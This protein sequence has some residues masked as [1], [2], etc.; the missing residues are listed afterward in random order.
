MISPL[1]A[2][3]A[4]RTGTAISSNTTYASGNLTNVLGTNYSG[5]QTGGTGENV[6][7]LADLSVTKS[8]P[9]TGFAG[10]T[11]T[12]SLVGRNLGRAIG[13]QTFS[14]S[15]ATDVIAANVS[16]VLSA[17]PIRITD[18]L[19][20]GVSLDASPTGTNW[21]CT[22]VAGNTS[23]S[24]GYFQPNPELAYPLAS[25]TDLPTITVPVLFATSACPGVTNTATISLTPGETATANNTSN[26]VTTSVGCNASL[27]V[28]KTNG[29][30]GLLAGSTTQYTVTF[31][32]SG[33][34][35]AGGAVVK[36]QPSAG[37]SS[38]SITSCIASGT[39]VCP[40]AAQWPNFFTPAGLTL[41]SFASGATLTFVVTCGVSATGL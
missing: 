5:L 36:D 25:N 40:A 41:P 35:G 28:T 37:L 16:T 4:N 17:N 11:G 12:Y 27:S 22:G 38:C 33:P 6:T 7:L 20:S 10:G 39:G 19:P 18:T 13:V 26:A 15:Q 9:A 24:C 29:S 31:V 2:V 30:T 21:T 34:A 23:F 8:G 14:T 3:N 1:T 32:N